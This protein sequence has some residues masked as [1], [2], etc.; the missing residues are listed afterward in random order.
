[1]NA[2]FFRDVLSKQVSAKAK[3]SDGSVTVEVYTFSGEKYNI[4]S[5]VEA[6]DSAV[7]LAVYPHKGEVRKYSKEDRDLGAPQFDFDVVALPYQNIKEVVITD[8]APT[9][10]GNLGFET[11]KQ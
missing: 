11:K 8:R 6:A 1:M 10:K 7:F 3:H 9:K 2:E 5:V 4:N